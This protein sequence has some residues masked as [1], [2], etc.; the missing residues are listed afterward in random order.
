MGAKVGAIAVIAGQQI[1]A[2]VGN[3]HDA[4]V[5]FF[6]GCRCVGIGLGGNP[7]SPGAAVHEG[8]PGVVAGVVSLRAFF[9]AGSHGTLNGRVFCLDEVDQ[10]GIHVVGAGGFGVKAEALIKLAEHI[11]DD[12]LLVLHG[13]HPDTE[14]LGLVLFPE[15]LTRQPQQAQGNF[16]PID[17]VMLLCQRHGFIVK[18]A[19]IGHLDGGFQAIIM[20]AL[21]LDFKDIQTFRQQCLAAD[22]FRLTVSGDLFRIL[23]HHLRAVDDIDNKFVHKLNILSVRK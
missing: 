20:G 5:L 6:I 17:L 15:L 19:G 4:G 14:I 13:E 7:G 8:V 11:P 12:G 21:L 1:T 22:V 16:V 18:Q 3:G 9:P 23:R 2:Q 10:V